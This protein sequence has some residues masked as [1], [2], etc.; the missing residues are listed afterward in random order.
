MLVVLEMVVSGAFLIWMGA[1]AA[2]VG[3]L[4]FIFP[5]MS[6]QGQSLIFAILSVV[7]ILAWRQRLKKHPT[8]TDQPTLNRRGEQYIGRVVTLST[9]LRDGVGK[10]TLDDSTWKIVG[11]DCEV[12]TRVRITGVDG[13]VFN[14]EKV[15]A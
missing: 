15:Q 6:W 3:V 8:A 14:V 1:A 5:Q 9:A 2:V 7:A 4:L 12:G 11:P 13:T 10:I